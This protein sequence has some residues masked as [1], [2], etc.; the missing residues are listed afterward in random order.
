MPLRRCALRDLRLICPL[1]GVGHR[2]VQAQRRRGVVDRLIGRFF[3]QLLVELDAEA[4]GF[5]NRDIAALALEGAA[6]DGVVGGLVV[7]AVLLGDEVGD[8]GV[9][10][11]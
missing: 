4:G 7:F 3:D 8:R 11:Q 6:V 10:L 9:E 1:D 2:A 5:G